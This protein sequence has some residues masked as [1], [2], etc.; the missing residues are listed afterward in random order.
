MSK[1]FQEH[2]LLMLRTLTVFMRNR[3]QSHPHDEV[4]TTKIISLGNDVVHPKPPTKIVDDKER[5]DMDQLKTYID[6]SGLS[7]EEKEQFEKDVKIFE[8]EIL[9]E[10]KKREAIEK[11]RGSSRVPLREEDQISPRIWEFAK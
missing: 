2:S 5:L 7:P 6:Q 8:L 11:Q 3:K 10:M 4:L 1:L 9:E